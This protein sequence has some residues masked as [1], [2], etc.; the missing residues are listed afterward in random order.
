MVTPLFLLVVTPV[1]RAWADGHRGYPAVR[2]AAIAV[3]F[4]GRI[5]Q[6]GQ[7]LSEEGIIATVQLCEVNSVNYLQLFFGRIHQIGQSL[8]EKGI[9]ATVQLFVLLIAGITYTLMNDYSV[10]C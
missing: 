1:G 10:A 2:L 3:L 4:F 5:H 7:L 9:I 8:S 6:I